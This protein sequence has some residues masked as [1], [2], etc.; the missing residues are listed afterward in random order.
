MKE[1]HFHHPFLLGTNLYLRG[2]EREDLDG[3]YFQWFNDQDVCAGN[4]HGY[5]PNNRPSAEAFLTNIWSSMSALVLAIVTQS[6]NKHI[7]NISLQSIDWISR[8]A[9][10]A[11]ILGEKDF[12][13]KGLGTEAAELI[14]NHGFNQLNL[15][16]IYCGTFA[17]NLGMQKLAIHLGMAQEGRRRSAIFKNGSYQ[18]VIEYGVLR[19]EYLARSIAQR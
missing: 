8:S 10:F 4:S 5:F 3:D 17:D 1:G 16:R 19:N 15:E 13:G 18:D 2:L 6:G 11:I 7:G 12:W 14:V 9:E